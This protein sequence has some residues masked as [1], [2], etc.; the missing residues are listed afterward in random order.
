MTGLDEGIVKLHIVKCGISGPPDTGKSRVRALMLGLPCP[1][2]RVST[3]MATEADIVTTDIKRIAAEEELIDMKYV[4]KKNECLWKVV[5]DDSMARV[6]AN[7]IHNR[8]YSKCSQEDR[9]PS[10]RHKLHKKNTHKVLKEIKKLLKH[11]KGIPKRKRRGLT[12]IHLLYFVDTGGQPQFQEILRNFIKCDINLLVHNLSQT[13]EYCPPFDYVIGG[14]KFTVRKE[15]NLSNID[16]IE[17]SVKSIVSSDTTRPEDKPSVAIVGTFKDQCTS[18][19]FDTMLKRKSETIYTHL[20]PYVG[21]GKGK[22]DLFSPGR[23]QEQR[24]FA[25]DASMEGWDSNDDILEKL[26]ARILQSCNEKATIDVPIK[27]YVLLLILKANANG[28]SVDYVTLDE[29][30]EIVLANE[31]RM[32][33]QEVKEALILFAECNTILYFPDILEKIAFIKPGFLFDKVTDLIVSSFIKCEDDI[34]SEERAYFRNTGVFSTAILKQVLLLQKFTNNFTEH[35]FLKLLK[36][37]NIVAEVDHGSYFMPC[38]LPLEELSSELRDTYHC[39]KANGIDGPFMITFR[40]RMSPRGLFCAILIALLQNKKW[41]LPHIQKGVFR[42]RNL[43]EFDLE[44]RY[45]GKVIVLDRNCRLEIYTTCEKNR[46]SEIRNTVCEAFKEACLKLNYNYIYKDT[47]FG[48]KC[49]CGDKKEHSTAVTECDSNQWK[50]RCLIHS[51]GNLVQ[52][53]KERLV[54]YQSDS[55]HSKS[56]YWV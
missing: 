42:Y 9:P 49:K 30:F 50:E 45:E 21:F 11:M 56:G 7:T 16:L 37:L 40:S 35:D 3:A 24:I 1:P 54:W 39:M 10:E 5:S 51:R 6:I 46:C 27:Y 23:S 13:L 17:Q 52:L 20:E 38:V 12:D 4:K 43:V 18:N 26:K 47:V 2:Q 33:K 29:C 25:I 32:N 36:G 14:K 28:K 15:L 53:T 44:G 31:M 8:D 48:F 19:D 55:H 34:M 22:C 41:T